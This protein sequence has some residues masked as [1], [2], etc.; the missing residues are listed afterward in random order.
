MKVLIVGQ[1]LIAGSSA[2]ALRWCGHFG[3]V[4]SP[5][6]AAEGLAAALERAKIRQR[7]L[8]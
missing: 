6:N 1:R 2:L 5:Q 8:E 4:D 3:E 7:L